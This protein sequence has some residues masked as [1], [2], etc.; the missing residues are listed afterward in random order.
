MRIIVGRKS[1]RNDL[2]KRMLPFSLRPFC[3]DLHHY[4]E[5]LERLSR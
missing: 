5:H 3:S 4:R 2:G 1:D